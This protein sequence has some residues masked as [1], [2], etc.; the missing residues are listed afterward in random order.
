MIAPATRRAAAIHLGKGSRFDP[1]IA[2]FPALYADQ[3]ERDYRRLEEAAA[4][5]EIRAAKDV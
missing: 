3:N 4:S 1:P 5:G 2:R